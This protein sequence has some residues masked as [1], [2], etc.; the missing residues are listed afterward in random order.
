MKFVWIRPRWQHECG[1]ETVKD[2]LRVNIHK[3]SPS[4]LP[5]FTSPSDKFSSWKEFVRAQIYLERAKHKFLRKVGKSSSTLGGPAR[6][7]GPITLAEEKASENQLF[8]RAQWDAFQEEVEV[9]TENLNSRVDKSSSIYKHSPWLDEF[10]VLRVRGRID[11]ASCVPEKTRRPIILPKNHAITRLVVNYFHRIYLHQNSEV[12][13]NE[14]CQLFDIPH[15]RSVVKDIQNRCQECRNKKVLPKTPEMAPLPP[16]RLAAFCRPF[17]YVGIDYF[18]PFLVTVGRH[19]EKRWGVIFTCLTIRGI[20]LEVSPSL[21]TD[22]F[23]HC[24]RFRAR[25]GNPLEVYSDNGTNF[26]GAQREIMERI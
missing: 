5:P 6:T 23:I 16:A 21:S 14:L 17:S 11:K 24:M 3:V 8:K 18:G 15:L 7:N 4:I 26:K 20:H 12:V 22:S 2:E 9:L 25:R 1:G 19:K 13:V 10:G